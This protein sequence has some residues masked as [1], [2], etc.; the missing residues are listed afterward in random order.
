VAD[1]FISYASADRERIRPLVEV[2]EREGWSVWWDRSL[3]PGDRFEETIEQELDA[4]RCVVVAWSAESVQSR[5]CRNEASE[6]LERGALVPLLLDKVRLPLSFRGTHA[7][8]MTSWPESPGELDAVLSAIRSHVDATGV[9]PPRPM[10]APLLPPVHAGPSI[11]VLP[12]VNMSNDPEQEYFSDG[13][14]EDILNQ[15]ARN[16]SLV[17][18]PKSSAFAMK[19]SH[20]D[21]QSI[22]RQLNVTHVLEGSV[23]RSGERI[24]VT[25]Q[26]SDVGAN[27]SIWSDRYDRELTDVFAVQ[28]E[29]TRAIVDALSARFLRPPP[30]RQFVNDD[31]YQALLLGR[32]HMSRFELGDAAHWLHIATQ[33][34]PGNADAWANLAETNTISTFAGLIPNAGKSRIDRNHAI[35]RALSIQPDHPGPLSAKA[36]FSFLA[37][38]DY[39]PAVD[40]L[41]ELVKTNTNSPE[42]HIH[43]SFV[44]NALRRYAAS[45]RVC[46]HAVALDP[47]SP[48]AIASHVV[49]V[50]L[51]GDVEQARTWRDRYRARLGAGTAR[52]NLAYVDFELGMADLDIPAMRAAMGNVLP[53]VPKYAAYAATLARA[54]G[55][56]AGVR[57]VLDRLAVSTRYKSHWLLSRLALVEGDHDSAL[58]HCRE[59]IRAAEPDAVLL[60]SGR[61][62]WEAVFPDFHALPDY[63]RLL[64]EFGLDAASRARVQVPALPF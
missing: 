5:W 42:A 2:L 17:V 33:L 30:P 29:I 3:V 62:P 22:A 21:L 36:L 63:Q 23:R 28:D 44:L 32:H 11:A 53:G 41:T 58:Y 46:V 24:R 6:G 40:V 26:L 52:Q 18:R 19:G 61:S 12:F 55:D 38:R 13:I 15:L 47:L 60:A 35:D 37:S 49:T 27:R 8:T 1:I 7:A 50:L 34:D 59:G 64:E 14:A 54:E 25:V 4:A 45:E 56:E 9:E 51:S 10:P 31:A 48:F 39:Q 57:D 43:L 20:H 16:S